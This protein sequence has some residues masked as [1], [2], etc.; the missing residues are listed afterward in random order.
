M[1]L[2]DIFNWSWPQYALLLMLLIGAIMS[3]RNH[4]NWSRYQVNFWNDLGASLV[5]CF[6]LIFGGFFA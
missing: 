2:I 1:P 6:F 4:G 3:G 5:I